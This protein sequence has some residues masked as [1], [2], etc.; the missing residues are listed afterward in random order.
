MPTVIITG[1]TGLIGKRLSALLLSKKYEVIIFS[2][3]KKEERD[4]NG[5]MIKHWD[6]NEGK[7]D[8]DSIAKADCIVHLA[9]TN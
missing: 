7:I 6:V 4:E 2:H 8:N 9:G 5:A 1:G 3:S